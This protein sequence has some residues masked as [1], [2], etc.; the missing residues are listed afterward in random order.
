V[1]WF[2]DGHETAGISALYKQENLLRGYAKAKTYND[3]HAS[4]DRSF[5]L[6][7]HMGR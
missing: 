4:F 6:P 7:A 5:H 3:R 2:D 1:I